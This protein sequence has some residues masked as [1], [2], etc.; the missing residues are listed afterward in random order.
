VENEKLLSRSLSQEEY[1]LSVYVGIQQ[2]FD[3]CEAWLV[4]RFRKNRQVAVANRNCE[5]CSMYII[6]GNQHCEA[7][8]ASAGMKSI[9]QF[10]PVSTCSEYLCCQCKQGVLNNNRDCHSQFEAII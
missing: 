3:L 5:M 4:G 2:G 1:F 9:F 7:R 6:A 8:T 10:Q